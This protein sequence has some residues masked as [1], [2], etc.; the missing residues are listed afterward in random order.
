[1][2]F[3]FAAVFCIPTLFLV[4]RKFNGR[5]QTFGMRSTW[6]TGIY[7]WQ[8]LK[9][10]LCLGFLVF[11]SFRRL[12]YLMLVAAAACEDSEWQFS[13][14]CLTIVIKFWSAI[15]YF[16]VNLQSMETYPTCLRQTGISCGVVFSNAVGILG[17]YIAYLVKFAF[18]GLDDI[19][20]KLISFA[21]TTSI[22]LHPSI[23][24]SHYVYSN[25]HIYSS[26][27]RIRL[28]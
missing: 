19:K 17:P 6:A 16:A 18:V 1:M 28:G 20:F 23:Q 3:F 7:I 14:T 5:R 26:E 25:H 10:F 27:L 15:T 13:A 22:H 4:N 11:L 8:T 2:S 21:H 12:Y 9:T 24:S